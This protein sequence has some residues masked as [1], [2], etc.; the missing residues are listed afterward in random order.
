[1]AE[2][3]ATSVPTIAAF[4]TAAGTPVNMNAA[5]TKH[6][7]RTRFV[8]SN[9]LLGFSLVIFL[10]VSFNDVLAPLNH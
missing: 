1:M 8:H 3:T 10:S 6:T 2:Q 4:Q 5:H 9:P 7:P